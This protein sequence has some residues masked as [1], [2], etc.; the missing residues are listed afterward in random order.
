MQAHNVTG[1]KTEK[2]CDDIGNYI[3]EFVESDERNFSFV[4]REYL[5]IRVLV[6]VRKPLKGRLKFRMLKGEWS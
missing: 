2:L 1:V 4:W 3:G 6:D 5:R